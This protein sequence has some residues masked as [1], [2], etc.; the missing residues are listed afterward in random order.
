[1]KIN[2]RFSIKEIPY[3]IVLVETYDGLD[4]DGKPKKQIKERFYPNLRT[5]L[6]AILDLTPDCNES[7]AAALSQ[8]QAAREDV[9]RAV[10][11]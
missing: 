2:D 7:L 9:L 1:M 4:K 11:A 10:S 6:A 5:A 8:I 3:N